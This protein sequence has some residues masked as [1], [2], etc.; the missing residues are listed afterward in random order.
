MTICTF[1]KKMGKIR[2]YILGRF[3]SQNFRWELNTP[4][5]RDVSTSLHLRHQI[6][7]VRPHHGTS[8]VNYDGVGASRVLRVKHGML[9]AGVMSHM[10]IPL[11]RCYYFI[12]WTGIRNLEENGSYQ[13]KIRI[14]MFNQISWIRLSNNLFIY[15]HRLNSL[16]KFSAHLYCISVQNSDM[17]CSIV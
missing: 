2:G 4:K 5:H 17:N 10:N 9:A 7:S 3:R 1:R 12:V 6:N 11:Y 15:C 8:R 16:Q 14:I 13:N